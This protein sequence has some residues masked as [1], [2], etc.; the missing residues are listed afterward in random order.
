MNKCEWCGAEFEQ[1]A[2]HQRFCCESHR[3][4]SRRQKDKKNRPQYPRRA[5]NQVMDRPFTFDT[6]LMIVMDAERGRLNRTAQATF[7]SLQSI[8]E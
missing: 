8:I 7:R 5:N 3:D 1:K 4:K 2:P 6:N